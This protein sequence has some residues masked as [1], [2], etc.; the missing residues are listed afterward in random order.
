MDYQN[1]R[2]KIGVTFSGKYRNRIEPICNSLLNLGYNK[3]EVFYDFWHESWLNGPHGDDKLRKIYNQQCDCVVVLL[4]PDYADRNWPGRIE[5]PA[6]KALIN[7]GK[8]DK[9]CLLGIDRVDIDKI[10]G[11]YINQAI[12]KFIDDMTSEEIADFIHEKYQH[13]VRKAK[14]SVT[15]QDAKPILEETWD[16]IN[17]LCSLNVVVA[18]GG[19]IN[20]IEQLKATPREG[21]RI[22][23]AKLNNAKIKARSVFDH[24]ISL[25][26]LADVAD[27]VIGEQQW[28]ASEI[29]RL[30]A[31]HEISEAIIGDIASYTVSEPLIKGPERFETSYR[32]IVVNK[33]ISLYA[34]QKQQESI[35]YLNNRIKP[36]GKR[37]NELAQQMEYFKALDHL[38]CLV[39]VWRYLFYYQ[40][41]CT[42]EQLLKFIRVMGDFF[43][44][45]RLTDNDIFTKISFFHCIIDVLTNKTNAKKYVSG[46]D[47]GK[48]LKEEDKC[49]ND[50]LI[51]LIEKVPLFYE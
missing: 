4:S 17:E 5:W 7:I 36:T 8:E 51:Y 38:D 23:L 43:T 31:Y 21:K 2:F 48:F 22:R 15:C 39:A 12:V 13:I 25:A 29:A 32:E 18:T 1:G 16:F 44:N 34:D 14:V 24:L 47:I 11:L 45:N 50:A 42:K 26:Y 19:S 46:T 6:V 3:D 30:I 37:K 35:G 49:V 10:S 33:F 9:I 20:I 40:Q 28:N 27:S 41:Q